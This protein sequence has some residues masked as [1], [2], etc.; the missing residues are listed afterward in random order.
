MRI[1]RGW[2]EFCHFCLQSQDLLLQI[3][4]L[5]VRLLQLFTFLTKHVFEHM[6]LFIN[7]LKMLDSLWELPLEV[8]KLDLQVVPLGLIN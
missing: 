3:Y 8:H 2:C 4:Y 7:Q 5:E 1:L 6:S